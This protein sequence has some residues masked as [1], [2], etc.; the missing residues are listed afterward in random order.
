[1][2][3]DRSASPAHRT[4]APL[5]S[6]SGSNGPSVS[7]SSS[8]GTRPRSRRNATASRRAAHRAPLDHLAV[9]ADDVL[10]FLGRHAEE[11]AAASSRSIEREVGVT[12]KPSS[13]RTTAASASSSPATTRRRRSSPSLPNTGH[14]RPRDPERFARGGGISRPEPALRPIGRWE[15]RPAVTER[16]PTGLEEEDVLRVGV[17]GL[18]GLVLRRHAVPQVLDDGLRVHR[19][20]AAYPPRSGAHWSTGLTDDAPAASLD[21][22]RRPPARLRSGCSHALPGPTGRSSPLGRRRSVG[23]RRTGLRR[24]HDRPA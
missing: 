17:Q 7:A 20:V 14:C 4:A 23:C 5:V 1:M 12:R 9:L 24:R 13:E 22:A 10:A 16:W 18:R 2:N 3:G 21:T 8:V 19:H 15:L 11:A 6:A